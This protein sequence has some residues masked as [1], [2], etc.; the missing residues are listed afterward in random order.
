MY[1]ENV[2]PEVLQVQPHGPL[3]PRMRPGREHDGRRTTWQGRYEIM[4]KEEVKRRIVLGHV[5]QGDTWRFGIALIH[6]QLT[7]FDYGVLNICHCYLL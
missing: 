7:P 4:S 6:E 5:T 2:Q 3:R 1:R